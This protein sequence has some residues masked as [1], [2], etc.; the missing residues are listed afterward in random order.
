MNSKETKTILKYFMEPH[1]L[2][3]ETWLMRPK[4]KN[5]E[6]IICCS[7]GKC[8]DLAKEQIDE[9]FKFVKP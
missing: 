9:T 4:Y 2:H 7:Y 3:E 6:L 1:Q 8:Y 5:F